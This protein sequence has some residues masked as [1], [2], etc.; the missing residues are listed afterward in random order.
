LIC[1]KEYEGSIVSRRDLRKAGM[2]LSA[3]C[4]EIAVSLALEKRDIAVFIVIW[5][6]NTMILCPKVR[7]FY[8][9]IW[10]LFP[11]TVVPPGFVP[12][13]KSGAVISQYSFMGVVLIVCFVKILLINK[14][15][16]HQ[17]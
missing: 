17:W 4:V 3:F 15:K 11:R 5:M 14:L 9:C 12:V 6:E 1:I 2:E 16:A 8:T 7:P 13:Q 10:I